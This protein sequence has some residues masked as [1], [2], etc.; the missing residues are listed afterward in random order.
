MQ[1]P[2]NITDFTS[3]HQPSA[4]GA[5]TYHPVQNRINDP[6]S[7]LAAPGGKKS[8]LVFKHNKYFTVPVENI[9]FFQVKY[10]SSIIVCLDKREYSVN[11]SL[12]QIQ[13]LLTGK[14]FFRVNRQYLVN[15]NAI[16]EV[17]HYFARKLLVNLVIAT[18]EKM[19]VPKE[20]VRL[21][22]DWLDNR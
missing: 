12:D 1:T 16:K 11:R 13:Q 18:A 3:T 5:G 19:L 7:D 20:K 10:E 22:L 4:L 8:F 6:V 15:F 17:E 21:F 9:A 2:I 14:Q